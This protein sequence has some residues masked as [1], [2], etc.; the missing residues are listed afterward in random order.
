M[1]KAGRKAL[2]NRV[3]KERQEKERQREGGMAFPFLGFPWFTLSTDCLLW[4]F[5]TVDFMYL[6]ITETSWAKHMCWD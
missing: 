3:R 5:T 6:T 4:L 2:R 1:M